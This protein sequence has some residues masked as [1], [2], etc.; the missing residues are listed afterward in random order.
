MAQ[1][2][3]FVLNV[4]APDQRPV[5]RYPQQFSTGIGEGFSFAASDVP[6]FAK[7]CRNISGL[8]MFLIIAVALAVVCSQSEG[9]FSFWTNA[10]SMHY[11]SSGTLAGKS[12]WAVVP[13]TP[14]FN[15][16]P[17]ASHLIYAADSTTTNQGENF[18]FQLASGGFLSNI[19]PYACVTAVLLIYFLRTM[20]FVLFAGE[21][22]KIKDFWEQGCFTKYKMFLMFSLLVLALYAVLNMWYDNDVNWGKVTAGV[23][24]SYQQSW[25][26]FAIGGFLIFL[27][28]F[29]ILRKAADL[30]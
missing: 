7:T 5:A 10:K 17:D 19:S 23:E 15:A 30:Q 21:T 4:Q 12:W 27:Y 29:Q 14:Y 26:S 1:F 24:F 16:D 22:H 6:D 9:Q 2:K 13:A 20:D 8:I 28:I 3:P 11:T 25:G 18:Q